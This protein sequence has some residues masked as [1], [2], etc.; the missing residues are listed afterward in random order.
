MVRRERLQDLGAPRD[1]HH[2]E[3]ERLNSHSAITGPK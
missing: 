1:L 3:D 2:A